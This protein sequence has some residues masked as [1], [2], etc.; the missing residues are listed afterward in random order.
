MAALQLLFVENGFGQRD[1]GL[2]PRTYFPPLAA[3]GD[4]A[5]LVVGSQPGGDFEI[6]RA[7]IEAFEQARE[8]IHLTAAY[9][10]PDPQLLKCVETGVID[11]HWSTVGSTNMDMRSFIFNKE[12]NIMVRGEAFGQEMEAAFREELGNSTEI[13]LEAWEPRPVGDRVKEWAARALA[14]WL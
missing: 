7:Y 2:E 8:S 1:H 10:V 6:Y 5:V 13:S 4:K 11:G 3:T 14:R 9:F 12:V